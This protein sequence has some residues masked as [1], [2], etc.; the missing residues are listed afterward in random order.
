MIASLA[1]SMKIP[2]LKKRILFTLG[3]LIVFRVGAFIPCPGIDA[4]K[5]E[6]LFGS[7]GVTDLLDMFSGGA[8]KRFSLLALGIAPYINSS[9]IMQLLVYVVPF[10]E[11]ISKEDGGRK[12]ITQY[13]RW[14]TVLIA[15]IQSFGIGFMLKTWGIITP[16]FLDRFPLFMLITVFSLTAGSVLIMR[17]GEEMTER[18]IGNGI[19]L[20]IFVGI[21]ARF[22]E[23]VMNELRKLIQDPSGLPR[24]LVFV[25]LAI[26]IIA[27]IVLIY[28]GQRKIPVQYAKRV[29]GRKVYGGASTHIPLRVN[30]AGVIPVIFASSILMFPGMIL[31]FLQRADIGSISFARAIETMQL[32]LRPGG[33]FYMFLFCVLII[34]FS[35]F[36][37]AITFN[38]KDLSDNM[39]KHGGFIPGLRPGRKTAEYIDRTLVRITLAG[40]V[41]LALVS[42]MPQIL[43]EMFKIS[44]YFGGTALIIVVGVGIDTMQQIESHLLTRHYEGFI[45]KSKGFR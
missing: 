20:L 29:V 24:M 41:F 9:I 37:T 4:V 36:Y 3:M 21:I 7:G 33:F 13:T 1:N 6:Q 23:A 42:I 17:L 5:L 43:A 35:Y 11:K 8:L 31:G 19:S 40:G 2:E 28:L 39:K 12:K 14:G 22:P 38:P 27:A 44:F 32:W 34:F 25:I 18:G 45:K 16:W 15:V 26:L 10:L 30:Q